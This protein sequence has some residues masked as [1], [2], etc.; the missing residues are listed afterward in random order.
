MPRN[1]K[2]RRFDPA[3]FPCFK[4][5]D[6]KHGFKVGPWNDSASPYFQCDSESPKKSVDNLGK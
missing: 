3:G 1:G 2:P 4:S 6:L 5:E